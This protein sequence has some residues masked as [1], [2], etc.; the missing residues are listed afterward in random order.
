MTMKRLEGKNYETVLRQ[1]ER[2]QVLT[3]NEVGTFRQL[4]HI[5]FDVLIRLV[6][7]FL[8]TANCTSVTPDN[9]HFENIIFS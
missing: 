4:C 2:H 9:I 7:N 6:N 5:G 1:P 8:M 3:G